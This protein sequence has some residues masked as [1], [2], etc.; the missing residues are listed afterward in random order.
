MCQRLQISIWFVCIVVLVTWQASGQVDIVPDNDD[1]SLF[2]H[3]EAQFA[4]GTSKWFAKPSLMLIFD[5]NSSS[6]GG[7]IPALEIGY[8]SDKLGTFSLHENYISLPDGLSGNALQLK[9]QK[10]FSK[11]KLNPLVRLTAEQIYLEDLTIQ[12]KVL[13]N[14]RT[15]IRVGIAPQ[16]HDKWQVFVMNEWFPTQQ[17]G[18]STE[19]RILTGM[20]YKLTPFTSVSAIYLNR[21][22]DSRVSSLR[23]QHIVFF[24]ITYAGRIINKEK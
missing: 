4:L 19:N 10:V 6:Y 21:Y 14:Y 5:D 11:Y 15:R 1:V 13:L 7:L 18:F 2:L 8:A 20:K 17:A 12:Q 24:S 22:R 23:W 3:T 9:W 16:M